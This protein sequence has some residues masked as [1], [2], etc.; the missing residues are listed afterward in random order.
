MWPRMLRAWGL[1]ECIVAFVA[2]LR[3]AMLMMTKQKHKNK[4]SAGPGKHW[5]CHAPLFWFLVSCFLDPCLMWQIGWWP[6]AGQRGSFDQCSLCG[7]WRTTL[8]R[9]DT[10][11]GGKK[12]V[13]LVYNWIP[14]VFHLTISKRPYK[15][16]VITEVFSCLLISSGQSRFG[17]CA[18]CLIAVLSEH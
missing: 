15:T 12:V 4:Q 13:F 8:A 18:G 14:I 7:L 9:S 11:L 10:T 1:P 6:T 3:K 16:T 17:N 2:E 5:V